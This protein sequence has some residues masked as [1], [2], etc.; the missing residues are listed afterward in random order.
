MDSSDK[1]TKRTKNEKHTSDSIQI[2]SRSSGVKTKAIINHLRSVYY[3]LHC[4]KIEKKELKKEKELL[5]TYAKK[6]GQF[7]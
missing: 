6:I 7:K 4:I 5:I 3:F 2:K 1:A